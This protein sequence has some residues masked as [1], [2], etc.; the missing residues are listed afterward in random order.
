M[1]NSIF[2]VTLQ[3]KQG[4]FSY[5]LYNLSAKLSSGT[6]PL[7]VM[8]VYTCRN[9]AMSYQIGSGFKIRYIICLTDKLFILIPYCV[10]HI[11]NHSPI[12]LSVS[13]K[14]PII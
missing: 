3:C 4:F 9:I 11:F 13:C 10:T 2:A 8:F 5:L 6:F 14:R 12:T 7:R 1:L